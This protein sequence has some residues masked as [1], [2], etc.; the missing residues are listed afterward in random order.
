MDQL[1][2]SY[3]SKQVVILVQTNFRNLINA[4]NK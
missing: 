4:K 3:Y 2:D 1:K